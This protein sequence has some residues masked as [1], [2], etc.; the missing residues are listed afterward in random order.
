MRPMM[1]DLRVWR[2]VNFVC[3]IRNAHVTID[4]TFY[5]RGGIN[6]W[7]YSTLWHGSLA[8][9]ILNSHVH[10]FSTKHVILFYHCYV[11]ITRGF[12]LTLF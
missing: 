4:V 2:F 7:G 8:Q 5:L 12:S 3:T 6:L 9:V 11:C 10:Q 1:C